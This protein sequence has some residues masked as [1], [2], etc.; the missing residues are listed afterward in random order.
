MIRPVQV[1]VPWTYLR[2][3]NTLKMKRQ[4]SGEKQKELFVAADTLTS[5]GCCCLS[6]STMCHHE[7]VSQSR[8]KTGL[9]LNVCH[10]Q[11]ISYANVMW[12]V[13]L[14]STQIIVYY[15]CPNALGTLILPEKK[16]LEWLSER[17]SR[18]QTSE[19]I[20]K[21]VRGGRSGDRKCHCLSVLH[22]HIC[23]MCT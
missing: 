4:W 12:N 21:R 14:Y 15:Y 16:C 5:N 18:A 17:F 8:W 20:W 10:Q 1:W 3:R 9:S 23:L 7:N 22:S 6:I 2:C 11:H 13:N 19:L